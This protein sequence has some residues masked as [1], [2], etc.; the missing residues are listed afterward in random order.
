MIAAGGSDTVLRIWD[1]RKPGLL[2]ETGNST[3]S[4][5]LKCLPELE[6]EDYYTFSFRNFCSRFP[7]LVS[8]FVDLGLQ[9]ARQIMVS[10]DISIL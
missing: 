6:T 8:H 5:E 3:N 4:H 7:I 2:V 9:V 1:P 10:F